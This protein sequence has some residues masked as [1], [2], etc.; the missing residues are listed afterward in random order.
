MEKE[1]MQ[2]ARRTDN[3]SASSKA[4]CQDEVSVQPRRWAT[5]F[6]LLDPLTISAKWNGE[7]EDSSERL[8]S[9]YL[10]NGH[11]SDRFLTKQ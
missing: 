1:T 4:D 9:L 7:V 3:L 6:T 11:L 10:Y 8:G 5:R 2:S